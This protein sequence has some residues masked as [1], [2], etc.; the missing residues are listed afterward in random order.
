M[1]D[2]RLIVTEGDADAMAGLTHEIL[3]LARA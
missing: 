2:L 1:S 3:S